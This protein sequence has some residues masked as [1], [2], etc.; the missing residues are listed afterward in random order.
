MASRDV[1]VSVCVYVSGGSYFEDTTTEPQWWNTAAQC[2]IT[3]RS[4]A[5]SSIGDALTDRHI[6]EPGGSL[7]RILFAK[8]TYDAT[9]PSFVFDFCIVGVHDAQPT[10]ELHLLNLRFQ[11]EWLNCIFEDTLCKYEKRS[12]MGCRG[13]DGTGCTCWMTEA[14]SRRLWIATISRSYAKW[15][16]FVSK[17]VNRAILSAEF[18]Q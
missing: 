17:F 6:D 4:D 9:F 16:R 5:L 7:G 3:L 13:T 18:P 15:R 12:W 2:F 1:G 8:G 10:A 11:Q 14:P